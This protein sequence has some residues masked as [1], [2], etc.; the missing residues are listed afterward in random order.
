MKQFYSLSILLIAALACTRPASTETF[1]MRTAVGNTVVRIQKPEMKELDIHAITSAYTGPTCILQ[2]D[3]DGQDLIVDAVKYCEYMP[4][5]ELM[6]VE[7]Y[8]HCYT[9]NPSEAE[10][11]VVRFLV[12]NLR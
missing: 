8:D 9:R 10:I 5:A 4:Q 12:D 7:G 11:P 2:G 1:S 6:M 3:K